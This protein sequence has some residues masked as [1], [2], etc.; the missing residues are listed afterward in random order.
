MN[1][2]MKKQTAFIGVILSFIPFGQSF[3]IKNG[4]VV[5]TA[6]IMLSVPK[7]V[8]ADNDI[9]YG[10][11]AVKS[12]KNE[13]FSDA[14]IHINQA[15]KIAPNNRYHFAM[16][17]AIKGR[18]GNKAGGCK[19]LKKAILMSGDTLPSEEMLNAY[20]RLNCYLYN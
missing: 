15:I 3:L 8:H 4:L 13:D 6:G 17:S 9:Y 20:D 1:F 12:Y 5:S 7:Q 14:L 11:R 2:D 10:E 16:R 18:M 19:D